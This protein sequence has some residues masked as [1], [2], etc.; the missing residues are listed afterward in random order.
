MFFN[1]SNEY[2]G[3]ADY[4]SRGNR[5]QSEFTRRQRIM[6]ED[7]R[8]EAEIERRRRMEKEMARRRNNEMRQRECNDVEQLRRQ[9]LAPMKSSRKKTPSYQI[10]QGPNGRLYRVPCDVSDDIVY[11]HS[12]TDI[13]HGLFLNHTEGEEEK[14]S[15]RKNCDE[16]FVDNYDIAKRESSDSESVISHE[17]DEFQG[18]DANSQMEIASREASP[19]EEDSLPRQEIVVEDVPNEEDEELRELRSVWRNRVPSPGQWIEPIEYFTR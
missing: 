3:Y 12:N 1:N 5:F 19:M 17:C 2:F 14:E 16:T 9:R 10:F 11:P 8:R 15:Y 7:R 18:I 4:P 6:E 13:D